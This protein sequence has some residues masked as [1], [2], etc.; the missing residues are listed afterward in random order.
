MLIGTYSAAMSL[1]GYFAQEFCCS[2]EVKD[3][4][5][6]FISRT[7]SVFWQWYTHEDHLVHSEGP[8]TRVEC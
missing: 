8:L 1:P 3:S 7:D 5:Y 2:C 6:S 4:L